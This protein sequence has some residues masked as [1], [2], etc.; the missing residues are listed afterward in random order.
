MY[1]YNSFLP[2]PFFNVYKPCLFPNPR[3]AVVLPAKWNIR[4]HL[5][6]NFVHWR[7]TNSP[8]GLIEKQYV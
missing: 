4:L 8:D 3:G 7:K 5:N 6:K 1:Y 2:D